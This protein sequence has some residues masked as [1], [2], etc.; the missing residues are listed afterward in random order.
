MSFE[1]SEKSVRLQRQLRA[2]MTQHI[3]PGEAVFAAQL[4]A[5]ENRF[6]ELPLIEELKQKAK[7]EDL[8]N[9]FVPESHGEY[10]AHGGLSNLDYYPLAETMGRVLW[11]AEVFNCNAPDSGNMEALMNYATPEQ[12]EKWLKPLLAGQIRSCYAMT[13]PQVASSDATNIEL[14][15]VLDGD[16]WQLDGRKWF[17]TGAMNART[18][19]II[20]MGK[21]DPHNPD[22]HRQQTQ[23]LVPIDT[24]GVEVVRAL[25][26]L[27]Y[28]DAP[29]GHAEI[30]FDRV[31]VPADNV[32]LGAGRGFEIAQGRLGPG[33]MHHCMRLVGAAQRALE[34]TCR[35]VQQRRTFGREL[36]R[37]QSVREDIAKSFSEIEMVQ[38]LVQRTCQRMDEVG[39]REARDLIAACKT[40]VPLMVQQILDRCI[41]LHGA[42]GLSRDFFLA[43]AFNYARWCRQA[44]G[45]DQVH[46]M[47]LGKQIIERF[48]G[49]PE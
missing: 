40:S 38:L 30:V 1:Y 37:H 11:S 23:L 32:L 45:P 34:I 22:R 13:E 44:D 46:Q 14:S 33:R 7:A 5:A 35:R 25:T 21:S 43:E 15:M 16:Q 8:W 4:A 39:A 17:I 29:I 10:S 41:Q 9:L 18:R 24:P 2:F 48:G 28:D 42:A 27:G 47:A 20:V 3:Y 26:T 6:G 12:Q 49:D 31:R 19:I 36:A